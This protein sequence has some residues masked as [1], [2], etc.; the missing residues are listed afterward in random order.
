MLLEECGHAAEVLYGQQIESKHPLT[1]KLFSF[2]PK[3]FFLS[4]QTLFF[5]YELLVAHQFLNDHLLFLGHF[6]D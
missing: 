2:L 1:L 4:K 6:Y 5:F 3:P